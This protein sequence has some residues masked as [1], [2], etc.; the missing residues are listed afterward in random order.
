M[1]AGGR[2]S[3]ATPSSTDFEIDP[4]YIL[5]T[6]ALRAGMVPRRGIVAAMDVATIVEQWDSAVTG[7]SNGLTML[8]DECG[9]LLPK[10][11]P[12]APML[13]P[14]PPRGNGWTR[15]AGRHRGHDV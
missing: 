11:L 10:W 14:L 13:P 4:Y 6:V 9:V 5:Q 3:N 12:Y 8:R 2:P 15:P 7:M 1:S